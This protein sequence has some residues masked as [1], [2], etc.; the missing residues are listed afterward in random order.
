MPDE[1]PPPPSQPPPDQ[2]PEEAPPPPPPVGWDTG[3]PTKT[4]YDPL[5][6]SLVVIARLNG[7]PQVATALSSGLPLV[8]HRLTT[9]LLPRAAERAGLSARLLR[10]ELE[11]I[12]TQVLPAIILLRQSRAAVLVSMDAAAGT[13]RIIRPETGEGEETISLE[14]LGEEYGGF[15][16]FFK[17][18]FAYD[19]HRKAAVGDDSGHW[20]WTTLKKSTS[21][22]R[23]VIIASVLIN[24]FALTSPM[25]VRNIYDRVVPNSAFE[26]LWALAIGALIIFT[27]DFLLKVIRT[28]FLDTA[29]RKSDILLSAKL[30]ERVQAVRL[31]HRPASVG[32][33]AKTVQEFE[34]IRDFITSATMATLVDIPFVFIFLLT[35]AILSGNLVLVPLV[36]II[37][38][39]IISFAI[40]Q[41][42]DE[43]I[44]HSFGAS[45]MKNGLLIET[46]TGLESVKTHR[47]EGLNQSRWEQSVG[48][49][50]QWS[51]RSRLFSTTANSAS[52][53]I[54][55]VATVA[56]MIVGVYEIAN[57]QNTMGG[58]IAAMMLSGRAIGPMSQVAG[59][60]GRYSQ[61]KQAYEG[62]AKIMEL[63]V[64][65][66]PNQKFIKVP[67]VKG[68]FELE[69]VG[70][71][72]PN[73]T[74][75]AVNDVTMSIPAGTKVAVIGKIGSGKSSLLRMLMGLY[76]PTEGVIKLDGIDIKQVDPSDL[77][78]L[79][80]CVEQHPFLFQGSIR[81]NIV[82]GS[83]HCTDEQLIR[84][85]NLAGV[86]DFT[87]SHPEG[88]NRPVGENGNQ[89]SGG[90]RQCVA[91]A[92]AMLRE[93][94]IYIMD[95][96]SSALDQATE[97]T[98]IERWKEAA[99]HK[100]MIIFTQRMAVLDAV[101]KIAVMDH[102]KLLI[103]GNK[104]DVLKK[105]GGKS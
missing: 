32:S 26:T 22:Y 33:Y 71:T 14:A 78:E 68:A 1:T 47:L 82:A 98:L 12:P 17:T 99:P 79:I 24:L 89:L 55:Q 61:T 62:V 73:Q 70:L 3:S 29:G 95:E 80:G 64:E 48:E 96:P 67:D 6:D 59:L 74:V 23:D 50:S 40:R 75:P 100:T 102:G 30:F 57:Q 76:Q 83:P 90:Q 18:K 88:L 28:H 7:N 10:R 72:F 37:I 63:D 66:E 34:S 9:D 41:P 53:W 58:L 103:Y 45:A 52:A 4:F 65:R 81:D 11:D 49:V 60:I 105:L 15:A 51:N 2:P 8:E 39:L 5:L 97:R 38:I 85:A 56:L 46:L 19:S 77:R 69:G 16:F 54:T 27:F 84:A 13:A 93:P 86:L 101:D 43:S 21:I 44:K 20:F 87:N 25:F 35:I 31:E 94:Q 104:A 92:R 91:I 42:V 36:A